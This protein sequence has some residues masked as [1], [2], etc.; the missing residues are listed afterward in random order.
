MA[1]NGGG[2]L[3][4]RRGA[5]ALLLGG[6]AANAAIA[7]GVASAAAGDGLRRRAP[8]EVGVDAGAVLDFLADVEAAKIDIHS[9]MLWR[10]GAVVVEGW[11]APYRPELP[12]MTHSLTK[13]FT[14]AAVG[15]A[16]AEGRFRLQDKVV[17]FFP[18]ELP[19]AVSPW[20]AAMTVEN[21]LAMKTGHAMAVSGSVWRPIRTSWVAEFFKI[22][23]V[24][25]PGTTFLYTSAATYMLSAIISKTTGQN[26]YA[27]LR[28]RL[29]EPLGITGDT[30]DA[31]P[32]NITP[33]ANGLSLPTVG[34]LKLAILHQQDGMWNG[35][36]VL[37]AG[38]AAQVQAPHTPGEYGWQWW[39]SPE[40]Y[41]ARGL[42]GQVAM[43][44]PGRQAVAAW[45]SADMDSR[46]ISRIFERHAPAIFAPRGEAGAERVEAAL[47][48]KTA[49]LNALPPLSKTTSP[50]AAVISGKRFVAAP[51]DDGVT[52]VRFDFAPDRCR[53][54]LTDARGEHMIDAGLAEWVE[55][56]TSMTGARLH[57]EYQLDA[58]RVVAG[59]SWSDP[60]VFEMTWQF[61]E[62]AFRD[63]LVCRFT[64]DTVTISRSVNVNS[65]VRSLPPLLARMRA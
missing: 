50:R 3:V 61:N 49:H 24:N 1:R 2:A 19:P 65:G 54:R 44:A 41:S 48:Y 42:F 15:M 6:L 38:W 36:R 55:S 9:F 22:P 30:W 5:G 32:N 7:A 56:Q 37:P 60:D 58:M 4:S 52:D 10:R 64:D 51:N 13:S 63:R 20:L 23:I 16:L 25:A 53:F 27:Y 33:G 43:V 57:H 14:A 26:T 45:T 17:S 46:S 28:P 12:H 29:F 35:R 31:G 47:G 8:N 39:L 34:M 40:G 18:D 59:G 62:S 11:W 21:L